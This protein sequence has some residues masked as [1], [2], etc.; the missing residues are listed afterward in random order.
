MKPSR[1]LSQQAT[2]HRRCP[3]LTSTMPRAAAS[4]LPTNR[5]RVL[6]AKVKA[7]NQGLPSSVRLA[8]AWVKWETRFLLLH[9]EARKIWV[10]RRGKTKPPSPPESAV[11]PDGVAS[12]AVRRDGRSI[13][14][15]IHSVT[16]ECRHMPIGPGSRLGPYEVTALIGEGGMGKVWRAHHTGLKRDDALKVLPDAFASDP[17]RLARFR[18]RSAGPRVAESSEH[19]ARLRSGAVGWCA[20][21]RHGAGRGADAG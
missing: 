9:N 10:E 1:S 4:N 8:S 13:H 20:G 6:A 18:A 5:L 21:A 15:T 7:N 14:R 2:R 12:D 19:R 11:R 17:D 16:V 3:T